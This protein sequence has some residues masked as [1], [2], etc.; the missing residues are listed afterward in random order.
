MNF[1]KA[2]TNPPKSDK[3]AD[4]TIEKTGE[5][6]VS[7]KEFSLM[8]KEMFKGNKEIAAEADKTEAL[9]DSIKDRASFVT[10][11]IEKGPEAMKKFGEKLEKL[12]NWVK[13]AAKAWPTLLALS[14]TIGLLAYS[15]LNPSPDNSRIDPNEITAMLSSLGIVGTLIIGGAQSMEG[16]I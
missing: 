13:R 14:V 15:F 4:T 5:K 2:F 8:I 9:G 16:T 12:A 10:K 6:S 7:F 11:I 1:N 3:D